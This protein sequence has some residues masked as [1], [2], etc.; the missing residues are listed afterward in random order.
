[1]RTITDII[2]KLTDEEKKLHEDII[3]ECLDRETLLLESR[4]QLLKNK[5]RLVALT[6]KMVDDIVVFNE[7]FSALTVKTKEINE[8]VERFTLLSIP[9]DKFYLARKR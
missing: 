9:D 4:S 7:I 6:K 8:D 2:L 3:S 1:M 5:K